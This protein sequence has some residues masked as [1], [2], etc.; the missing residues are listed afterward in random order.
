MKRANTVL[1]ERKVIHEFHKLL[2]GKED[3]CVDHMYGEVGKKVFLSKKQTQDIVRGYY[4]GKITIKMT[5]FIESCDGNPHE[6][7]VESFSSK[8]KLCA[9]ESRLIINY[10]LRRN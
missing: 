1:K 9:R 4:N 2:R 10:I 5:S 3:L 7:K 6:S 8:F